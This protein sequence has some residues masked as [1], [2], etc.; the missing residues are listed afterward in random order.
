MERGFFAL[1]PEQRRRVTVPTLRYFDR[2][3]GSS[4]LVL[5]GRRIR[6]TLEVESPNTDDELGLVR[7]ACAP[8]M[9]SGVYVTTAWFVVA[10]GVIKR[11]L[12]I[13]ECLLGAHGEPSAFCLLTAA[14]QASLFSA[15]S[16]AD[17]NL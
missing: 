1:Q 11:A 2:S 7:A 12:Q 4:R 8:S 15:R 10:T 13:R 5:Q 6:Q 14:S 3:P 9:K 16:L 17:G